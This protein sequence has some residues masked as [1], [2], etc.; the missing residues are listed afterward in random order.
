MNP[1]AAFDKVKAVMNNVPSSL[2]PDVGVYGRCYLMSVQQGQGLQWNELPKNLA[3]PYIL[4]ISAE[5]FDI[6]FMKK[7]TVN[8]SLFLL[9]CIILLLACDGRLSCQS[10]SSILG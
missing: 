3:K 5:G 4:G 9:V 6:N 1:T 2:E 8:N 10:L 7:V